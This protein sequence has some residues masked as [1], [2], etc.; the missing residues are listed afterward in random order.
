M[1][2]IARVESTR[3]T[4]ER[5]TEK[6]LIPRWVATWKIGGPELERIKRD[7]LRALTDED[8]CDQAKALMA[9]VGDFWIE[10]RRL[11]SFGLIEQQRIISKGRVS[12]R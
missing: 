4:S 7:E 5:L 8:E 2:Y 9:S 6:D 10:P 3:A 12:L 1:T 11:D